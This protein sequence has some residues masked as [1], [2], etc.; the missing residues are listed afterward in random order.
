MWGQL[1]TEAIDLILG[2]FSSYGI[3]YRES[4]VNT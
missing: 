3:S 2:E 4:S 1:T